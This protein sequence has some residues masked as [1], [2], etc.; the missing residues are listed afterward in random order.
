MF[1]VASEPDSQ[2]A[3]IDAEVFGE[4][5]QV[6]GRSDIG[7]ERLMSSHFDSASLADGELSQEKEL[8][9]DI[10]EDD[11]L[12]HLEEFEAEIEAILSDGEGKR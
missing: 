1:A 2:Y 6:E 8:E 12:L 3:D 4:D 5:A 10:D 9:V 7:D 11:D